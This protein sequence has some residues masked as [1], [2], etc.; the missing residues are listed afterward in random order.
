ML[1]AGELSLLSRLDLVYR[2][3]QRGLYAGERRSAHAARSP[4]FADFRPYVSGDDFRQLDW[5]AYARLERLVLRLYV[6]E[7]EACL[8]VLLDR[9]A[10]MG[11][12]EPAKWQAARKLGAALC[13]LGLTAMDRVQ[14][15]TLDG[16]RLAPV[17]GR[18]GVSRIWD[19]MAALEPD[20]A[21][22]PEQ[23]VAM[24]WL[25]PGMTI[26]IS[27]FL[28]GGPQA[29]AGA[30]WGP[31]LAACRSRRQEPVLWQVLAPEEEDPWLAGDVTLIDVES[32]QKRELTIT[33]ALVDEYVRGLAA[34]RARLTQAAA[35]GQGRFLHSSSDEDVEAAMLIGLRAGVVQRA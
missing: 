29:G 25:R 9:S 11:L 16:K 5:K 13:V 34:H 32:G 4:E 15:G 6:A 26:I 10:S 3:P 27:D 18:E 19:F 7:E 17:R 1:S 21:V 24:R 14:V 12:G 30:D 8:N 31:A 33:P 20:G 2:R 28:V 35:A 23:L 22:G